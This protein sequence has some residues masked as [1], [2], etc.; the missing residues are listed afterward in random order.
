[1]LTFNKD[2]LFAKWLLDF[3]PFALDRYPRTLCGLFWTTL[4]RLVLDGL[5]V[6]GLPAVILSMIW[7]S[8]GVVLLI[9]GGFLAIGT[10][11]SISIS[12][13]SQSKNSTGLVATTFWGLK[14]RLCPLVKFE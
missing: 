7:I 10:I 13:V 8:K 12:A 2:G 11:G 14:N 9:A 4:M 1:M 6:V 3:G 5:V